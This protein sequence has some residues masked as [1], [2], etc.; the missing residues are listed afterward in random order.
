MRRSLV[1]FAVSAVVTGVISSCLSA[2]QV[3]FDITT[4]IPCADIGRTAI[5]AGLEGETEKADPVKVVQSCTADGKV[6]A[7][8]TFAVYPKAKNEFRASFK[9][10][11][12]TT[13][14]IDVTKA[15]TP[16]QGYRGCIV[17]RR[18]ISFV[19]HRGL[20]VPIEMLLICK[21]VQCDENSTCNKLGRCVSNI[22]DTEQCDSEGNCAALIT[23]PGEGL[24]CFNSPQ[25]PPSI[26][27]SG[28][29]RWC[30]RAP[31]GT[32]SCVAE[33][34]P[35]GVTY[36][37][38]NSRDCGPFFKCIQG[39][40]NVL[41]RCVIDVTTTDVVLCTPDDVVASC[42]IGQRLC[43]T[44][45]GYGLLSCSDSGVGDAGVTSGDAGGSDAGQ[46]ADA[47]PDAGPSGSGVLYINDRAS[48][49]ILTLPLSWTDTNVNLGVVQSFNA[50]LLRPVRNMV[51]SADGRWLFAYDTDVLAVMRRDPTTGALSA[52][53]PNYNPGLS[54][55]TGRVAVHPN[56][57]YLYVGNDC[58]NAQ[59]TTMAI[60]DAGGPLVFDNPDVSNPLPQYARCTGTIAAPDGIAVSADGGNL[61]V[62]GITVEASRI[63]PLTGFATPVNKLPSLASAG[64]LLLVLNDTWLVTG[65]AP[66]QLRITAILAD[67]SLDTT[68]ST[69]IAGPA[70]APELATGSSN[71]FVWA[72]SPI[73]QADGGEVVALH[74]EPDGTFN[75]A[76]SSVGDVTADIAA[77]TDS[78]WVVVS[79]PGQNKLILSRVN[80]ANG[81][82]GP[83]SMASLPGQQPG[84]LLFTPTP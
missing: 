8:G 43:V 72:V 10:T 48:L 19:A 36:Q 47:G 54:P 60:F 29:T 31:D 26:L 82:L 63:D 21:D 45:A 41:G 9:V 39:M 16:S 68:R 37:C 52:G 33:P 42:A 4:D 83:Q 18:R 51:V 53:A 77:F 6:G 73:D 50:G 28:D 59:N 35:T 75:L 79:V 44:D 55:A 84:A 15:C 40:G 49:Q 61:Y 65:E 7:I 71:Q 11:V 80:G 30:Y 69:A 32:R 23:E 34:P 58:G 56:G 5:T 27:C 3:T 81:M 25:N 66:G 2:T 14:G 17:S 78:S 13:A 24:A 74:L 46:R 20:R 76:R 1:T 38:R 12:A 70:G 67:G 22:V 62:A 64:D 57:N